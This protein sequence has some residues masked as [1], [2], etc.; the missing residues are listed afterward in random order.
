MDGAAQAEL[1]L[2]TGQVLDD[3]PASGNEPNQE[4]PGLRQALPPVAETT[5]VRE[6]V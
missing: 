5:I 4:R 1:D 2:P 6:V 3:G